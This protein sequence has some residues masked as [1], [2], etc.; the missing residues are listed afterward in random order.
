L[1]VERDGKGNTGLKWKVAFDVNVG[2]CVV[3]SGGKPIVVKSKTRNWYQAGIEVLNLSTESGVPFLVRNY[4][5]RAK[6]A[7]DTIQWADT[8]VTQ[9]LAA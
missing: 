2:D 6:N 4:L 9:K 3:G 5:V 7:Q 1:I 8:P